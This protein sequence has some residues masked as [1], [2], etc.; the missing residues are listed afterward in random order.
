MDDSTRACQGDGS[1]D[2]PGQ[3]RRLGTHDTPQ[4]QQCLGLLAEQSP[5]LIT[6]ASDTLQLLYIANRYEHRGSIQSMIEA[7]VATGLPSALPSTSRYAS[8][9]LR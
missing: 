4:D 7:G 1:I 9:P 5:N 6:Y 8:A 2:A 3:D